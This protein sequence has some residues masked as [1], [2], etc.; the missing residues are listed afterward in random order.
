LKANFPQFLHHI[1]IGCCNEIRT[2]GGSQTTRR[3]SCYSI[4]VGAA[5]AAALLFLY[6]FLNVRPKGLTPQFFIQKRL[7]S[8]S[9]I[10]V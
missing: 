5:A 1:I 6:L 2:P 8:K 10:I 7:K 3:W 4:T 9:I